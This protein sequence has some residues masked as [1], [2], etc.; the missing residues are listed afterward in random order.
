MALSVLSACAEGTPHRSVPRQDLLNKG[1]H[2]V[3]MGDSYTSAPANGPETGQPGCFQTAGNYPHQVA[4]RLGLRLTDVSCGGAMTTHV[5]NPQRLGPATHPPQADALS[6]GTDLVTISLGANDFGLFGAVVFGCVRMRAQDP[7]G[8]PCAAASVAKGVKSLER[9]FA[10]IER[11]LITIIQLVN[12]RS[13][14]ARIVVVG[15]PQFFP[16]AGPCAQLQLAAGDFRFAYILSTQ[17]VKAQRDAATRSNVDYVDV[18]T[19]TSGHDMCADDPWIAGQKPGRDQAMFY[20]PY[21]EEQRAVA[22]LLVDRL[23]LPRQG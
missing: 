4:K 18:F 21:P 20:H 15:Y 10:E 16:K 2:Y 12:E 1:D 22:D 14:N 11:R 8:A 17:L 3:A 13:P 5:T 19:A 23:G 9:R 7:A 6:S